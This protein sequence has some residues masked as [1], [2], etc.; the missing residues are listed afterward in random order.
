[1]RGSADPEVDQHETHEWRRLAHSGFA[2]L[3]CEDA[4]LSQGNTLQDPI[5]DA[6]IRDEHP[7]DFLKYA[8]LSGCRISH[9]PIRHGIGSLLVSL[10]SAPDATFKK[11]HRLR[12]PHS[13]STTEWTMARGIGF[14]KCSSEFM[15]RIR[16]PSVLTCAIQICLSGE[17]RGNGRPPDHLPFGS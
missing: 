6:R 16:S 10:D 14:P 2:C 15:D 12:V 13:E 1:V 9:H 17:S 11:I 8:S 7:C 5:A 3:P 4:Q